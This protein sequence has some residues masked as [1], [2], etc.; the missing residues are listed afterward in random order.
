M[1]TINVTK[2][3]NGMYHTRVYGPFDSNGKRITKRI[4]GYTER[5]VRRAAED[6]LDE[7]KRQPKVF[8]MTLKD[9]ALK[10]IEYLEGKRKPISPTTAALYYGMVKNYF[11]D[12]HNKS[13]ISI[14]EEMLQQ[15]IY[16]LERK[17][18]PK[19]VHNV[20]NF[21][22]PCIK[23]SRRGFHPE[24]DL[25]ELQK[26]VTKVPDMADL[27]E[28]ISSIK[29]KRLKIPVLLAAYC[30]M[31]RSEIVALDLAKDIEYNREV[32]V[33][34]KKYEVCIIHVDK[35]IVRDK[36]AQYV[37]KSTKTE[38]G[39][40]NLFIPTWLGDILKDARDDPGYVPYPPHKIT[41]RFREWAAKNDIECS[42]HGLR[43]FYASIMKALNIPDNYAM[44]LMGHTTDNMLKR[45]Q[46]IMREKE[47]QVNTDLLMYLEN[48]APVNHQNAPL[49]A[50]K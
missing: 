37:S 41:N 34:G 25:P 14:T 13:I 33:N 39:T 11:C 30:G 19:T 8:G 48:N 31:R 26:P 42:F 49:D 24:L 16:S 18:S 43:H 35:A 10:Y 1:P 3:K 20:V 40:R 46:E 4:I 45:Y 9:A 12:L 21:Y 6:F 7:M 29:N 23:H 27:K 47:L 38:A 17:V 44:L 2:D 32:H 28:K 22:V 15:E 36:N 5:E 50:D